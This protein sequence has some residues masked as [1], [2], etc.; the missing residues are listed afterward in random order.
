MKTIR[1]YFNDAEGEFAK[2]LLVS[3]GI[4]AVLAEEVANSLGPGYAPGGARLQVPEE[5][6]ERALEILGG[7]G[8][9]F[10]PLP[11]DFVPPENVAVEDESIP[12]RVEGFGKI[13][14]LIPAGLSILGGMVA[15]LV[16]YLLLAPLSWTHTSAELIRMGNAAAE[17]KENAR[18]IKCYDAA[19]SK[20][21]QSYAASY[22]RGLLFFDRKEYEKAIADF[23]EALRLNP[24]N[25]RVYNVRG[26]AYRRMGRYE[27]ALN[28]FG[29]VIQL[30]PKNYKAYS[31]RGLVYSKMGDASRAIEDCNRAMELAPG[32]AT[33]YNNLA[34]IYATWPKPG[35]RNGAKAL[36][37][38]TKACQLSDWKKYNYIG[39]L[40]AAEAEAGNFEGAIRHQQQAFALARADS[41]VDGEMLDQMVSALTA[42]QQEKPYRDLSK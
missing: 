40:A 38:A 37:F 2:S 17:K 23:T 16:C 7:G 10:A 18:A 3:V 32:Q 25:T 28:D 42:Y 20:N 4:K 27:E 1:R 33:S 39:T 19:L 30:E 26:A 12:L 35:I 9:E 15:V 31:N 22:D 6:V 34:W 5:D 14:E 24:E 8:E 29:K 11:D 13:K 21:P 36:E 41:T